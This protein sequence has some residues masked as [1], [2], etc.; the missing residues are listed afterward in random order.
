MQND[1]AII[2]ADN[3][4]FNDFLTYSRWIGASCFCLG[5]IV[6]AI[7]IA[8]SN[9]GVHHRRSEALERRVFQV[10]VCKTSQD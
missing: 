3:V 7:F 9:R 2:N 5:G 8:L 6:L 10:K 4:R 1:K